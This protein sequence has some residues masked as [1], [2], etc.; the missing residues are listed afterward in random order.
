MDSV[1]PQRS[2]PALAK[3]PRQQA[4]EGYPDMILWQYD[5]WRIVAIREQTYLYHYEQRW[6]I[7]QRQDGS[8]CFPAVTPA[9]V[10]VAWRGVAR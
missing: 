8:W 9:Y 1:G 3:E 10:Q 2:P 4:Q 5:S 6:E 7:W